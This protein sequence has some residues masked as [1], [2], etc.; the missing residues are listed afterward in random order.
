[1]SDDGARTEPYGTWPSPISADVVA[2]DARTFGH[3]AVDGQD[4][5]WRE[6]RPAEDGRGVIVRHD[7][8]VI[9][10][11]TPE[12]VNVRTLVH[13]YGGGDFTVHDGTVFFAA[14]DDQRVY[15]QPPNDEPIAITP[16]PESERGLRYADFEVAPDGRH[17]YCVRE[18]HD[19]TSDEDG[20]E[21]PMNALVRLA[22]DGSEEPEVI[23]SGHDFYAAPRLSP[24]GDRLA[25]LTWDH[26]RMPW[27]GTELHVAT[28]TDN[29]TLDD[30]RVVLGGNAEA[31]FQ[32][33]WAP[34]GDLYVASD[35]SGWWNLYR[36]PLDGS[37]P[38]PVIERDAEY[39]A[40][41]WQFGMA[42]FAVLD[43]GTIVA[44]ATKDGTQRVELLEGGDRKVVDLPFETVSPRIRSNGETVTLVAGGPWT[45]TS[46][47][48]CTPG[49]DPEVVRRSTTLEVDDAYLAKPEHV[50]YETRDGEVSHAYVYPPTNPEVEAPAN[51]RP[52]LVVFAHGGPTG[53]TTPALNLTI[54]YF[55][56]RGFA[57]ADVNYRGS[58]GYGR[59]YREAL[60]GEWG[61]TDVE[62]T[63]DAA[64]HL[65]ETGRADPDR[66][67]VRGGSAGGFVVLAALAF[68]DAFDAGAS[69]FGVADLARLAELTHKFESRYLDQLVGPYPE[70]ADTYRERSPVE[71]ADRIDAPV[72][73]LQG[74]DDPVV[75]LSQAEAMVDA[76][77]EDSVPH[78]LLV[79]DDERHGFRRADSRKRATESELAF[80]GEVF[81]FEP[82]DDLPPI[83]PSAGHD[84]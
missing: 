30:E 9:E 25:W 41:L 15:R 20:A 53:A 76:L 66:L 27:D 77:D 72:L 18:N 23:T 70:A 56:S 33:T 82:V 16:A 80:Y 17:V 46:V 3:V 14:F 31:V 28:V 60:Y 36:V 71:H 55:T 58:T 75:P 13:E 79:F 67:A 47:V 4:V 54:Q 84:A 6:Q 61:T 52:P 8:E 64:I 78:S 39:G 48:R 68:H 1:M 19:V 22:A 83:D 29:G 51:E 50:S 57:V 38:E 62:D 43:D 65:A 2:S 74:E 63:V 40:P 59:E 35:R 10:D 81:G 69:Y 34:D 26:P 5:Y 21:E 24:D 12:G 32:P 42:T 37:A 44:I 73:L 45:P 11:V 7:G 49:A